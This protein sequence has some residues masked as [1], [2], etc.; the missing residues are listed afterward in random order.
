MVDGGVDFQ[1]QHNVVGHM[2]HYVKE[3]TY[4]VKLLARQVKAGR[5]P[6]QYSITDALEEAPWHN[7]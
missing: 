4:T 7:G 5:S 6:K 3:T 2:Y 1:L